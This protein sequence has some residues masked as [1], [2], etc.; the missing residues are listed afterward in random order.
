MERAQGAR[1]WE[2]RKAERGIFF[3]RGRRM[4]A[5]FAQDFFGRVRRWG[6]GKKRKREREKKESGRSG[7]A[8]EMGWA[9]RGGEEQRERE[10]S[11]AEWREAEFFAKVKAGIGIRHGGNFFRGAC[12][13]NAAA[14]VSAFRAE[15]D[16]IIG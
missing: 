10:V 14:T 15:I 8:G 1:G 2:E 9:K 13:N 6:W 4:G 16:Q 7:A 12:G 3:A 5:F 11:G